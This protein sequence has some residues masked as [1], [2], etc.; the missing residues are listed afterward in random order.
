M[1][2]NRNHF[3]VRRH[4]K[5]ESQTRQKSCNIS[6]TSSSSTFRLG[7]V[8]ATCSIKHGSERQQRKI[9]EEGRG[10]KESEDDECLRHVV[11]LTA[12]EKCRAYHGHGVGC[13]EGM[14]VGERLKKNYLS[15]GDRKQSDE[16][17]TY[18]KRQRDD[19]RGKVEI[20]AT[21]RAIIDCK[22]LF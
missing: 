1:I 21:L 10:G 11:M 7:S 12:L 9:P 18:S 2:T 5:E 19:K 4:L 8:F 17:G 13:Q 15:E 20:K 3:L 14:S 6:S 16:R 22:L